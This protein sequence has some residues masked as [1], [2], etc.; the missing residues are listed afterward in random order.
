MCPPPQKKKYKA[1]YL[2]FENTLKQLVM[3]HGRYTVCQEKN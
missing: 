1:S 2:H 3:L